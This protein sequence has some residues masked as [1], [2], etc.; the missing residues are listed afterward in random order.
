MTAS[1]EKRS[2]LITGCSE[3]GSGNALALAFASQGMR[4]FATA[5]SLHT[6]TN[7]EANGIETLVLDVTNPDSITSLRDE[8][9]KRTHGKLDILINNAG[10]MYEAPALEADPSKVKNMFETNVF[11]LF[12]VV[13]AFTPL[14]L[15]SVS[16]SKTAPVIVNVASVL[17]R[18]PFPFSS[19]YN[20][21]KAAVAAYS[22]TLRLEL[23]PLGIRVVTLYM[24]E[25]S[26]KLMSPDN[27][28]FGPESIYVDLE[29]KVKERSRI[30]GEESISATAFAQ[31]VMSKVLNSNTNYIWKGSRA[32]LI[33]FLNAI[34]P[35][36]VF[37][38]AM[39]QPVGLDNEVIRK[40][41]RERAEKLLVKS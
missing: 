30:H 8:I 37:D 19:A 25:V 22:D 24:G 28:L 39:N 18:L 29:G 5:R 10:T 11:G 4:V 12:N 38:S 35:R 20:A 31:Q 33:W 26:T 14:L 13:T 6:L 1:S 41:I 21:S 3:G 15:A 16:G 36:K 32:L 9:Q 27:I 2:I 40:K 34:G 17:A 7:L 23:D